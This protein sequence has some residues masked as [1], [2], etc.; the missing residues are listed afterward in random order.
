MGALLYVMP[1]LFV[2][3]TP[4]YLKIKAEFQYFFHLYQSE[5]NQSIKRFKDT[6]KLKRENFINIALQCNKKAI[7]NAPR[8]FEPR[9][10]NKDDTSADSP[11]PNYQIMTTG[12]LQVNSS[13]PH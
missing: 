9:S 4:I 3:Y 8:N 13:D 2:Q 5:Q 12:R 10:S 7:G 1:L 6:S 11:S